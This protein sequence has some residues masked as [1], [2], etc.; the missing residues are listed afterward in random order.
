[1]ARGSKRNTEDAS[2]SS[3][4][5]Y[6]R[7]RPSQTPGCAA[8]PRC[9]PSPP[10][11]K[12][13]PSRRPSIR[14]S[15]APVRP[16]GS[17]G[18]AQLDEE[19]AWP[20]DERE[21][22]AEEA[23]SLQGTEEGHLEEE[24]KEEEEDWEEQKEE[25]ID[26]ELQENEV[27]DEEETQ[28]ED[29]A[30][31]QGAAGGRSKAAPCEPGEPPPFVRCFLEE[32]EHI[33][34]EQLEQIREKLKITLESAECVPFTP[35]SLFEELEALPS[36]VLRALEEMGATEPMPIQAQALPIILAGHDLVGIA[37][38]GSGKTL[39]YLLPA[40]VHIEAQRPLAKNAAEPVALALAPTRELAHQIAEE[41]GKLLENSS[42]GNH[43]DGLWAECIYGGKQRNEQL[44]RCKGCAVVAAT[45]GRLTDFVENGEMSLKRVT[46]FVLDEADRMLDFGFADDVKRI[47]KNIRPDRHMLFF[48]ATWPLEVQD[49]AKELCHDATQPIQLSVD[50]REDGRMVSRA[51]IVQEVV[52]FDQEN[53]EE[54]EAAKQELLY[55]HLR[56]HL[57][58]PSNKILVFVSSKQL[59]D[60]LRDQLAKEGFLTDSMHGGRSQTNRD[61]VFASF[62]RGD[63]K[64]LVA[65]DVMGRGIDIPD[66][67][68]VVIYD[69]GDVDDYVHRIGRTCRGP[70]GRPGH[71]LTLFEYLPKWSEIAGDLVRLLE[72]AD[73]DVPEALRQ[74]AEEVERGERK[75]ISRDE[76]GGTAWKRPN[77]KESKSC[78]SDAWNDWKDD[79]C[80]GWKEDNKS[81]DA[82]GKKQGDSRTKEQSWN[83]SWNRTAG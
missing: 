57:Q 2:N 59:A 56:E 15:A 33:D 5:I 10:W 67:S 28:V 76:G 3:G 55:A 51:D 25:D 46:Y 7:V 21:S 32:P 29:E 65:T 80:D 41:A 11:K 6:K 37:R 48:S 36:Y 69:M 18:E 42:E 17:V 81:G 43:S 45:P 73:Q 50:Q 70:S 34:L 9:A 47:A 44:R 39:A 24:A 23:D 27:Q 83:K 49:L 14:P 20:E 64:L 63:I 1:M 4:A 19:A 82:W 40:V 54:R 12:L 75:I 26:D 60:E 66:V 77:K 30:A 22:P 68:H 74:V 38:T 58:D 16:R 8:A 31:A 71:A 79:S 62:K 53:W 13:V 52:V 78:K 61:N 35:V 72:E